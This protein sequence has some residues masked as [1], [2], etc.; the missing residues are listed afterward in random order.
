MSNISGQG[1]CQA[2]GRRPR[3]GIVQASVRERKDGRIV[4]GLSD[5]PGSGMTAQ[6]GIEICLS[7]EQSMRLGHKLLQIG[8]HLRERPAQRDE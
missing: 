7:P 6:D 8:K 5:A 4:L 1:I 3:P 2:G